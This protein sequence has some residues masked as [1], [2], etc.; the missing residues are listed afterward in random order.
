MKFDG[1]K[2]KLVQFVAIIIFWCCYFQG[3]K[4][5]APYYM[6]ST[7]SLPRGAAL[8]RTYSPAVGALPADRLKPLPTGIYAIKSFYAHGM[9]HACLLLLLL[10]FYLRLPSTFFL[11]VYYKTFVRSAPKAPTFLH[12]WG[13]AVQWRTTTATRKIW[14]I[15]T[16]HKLPLFYTRWVQTIETS[17]K[18][19]NQTQ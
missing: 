19:I 4:S 6:G 9:Q 13:A 14:L 2:E 5:A 18:C 3:S 7:A 8:L 15:S 10:L 17:C 11:V 1:D 16:A 12:R